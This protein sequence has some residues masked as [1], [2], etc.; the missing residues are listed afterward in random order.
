MIHSID[1]MRICDAITKAT[2]ARELHDLSREINQSGF[3]L[4][5]GE[6]LRNKISQRFGQINA[7]AAGAERQ[8]YPAGRFTLL[9]RHNP[10]PLQRHSK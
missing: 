6:A 7:E 5:E 3:T 4:A 2:K 1:Y 9:P 8:P 10:S